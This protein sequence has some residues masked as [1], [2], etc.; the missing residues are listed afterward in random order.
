MCLYLAATTQRLGISYRRHLGSVRFRNARVAATRHLKLC[1][2]NRS[3]QQKLALVKTGSFLGSSGLPKMPTS[4]SAAASCCKSFAI[5][6]SIW[7]P[8]QPIQ[9]FLVIPIAVRP[10]GRFDLFPRYASA[11][12]AT[13]HQQHL[14]RCSQLLQAFGKLSLALFFHLRKH[15]RQVARTE[16]LDKGS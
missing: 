11:T 13:A 8:L 5:R 1:C 6:R 15:P 4:V 3:C 16:Y 12:Q 10:S 2:R 9:S 7:N 14:V